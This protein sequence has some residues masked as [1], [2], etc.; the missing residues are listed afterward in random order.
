M[1]N[2]IFLN[3][4]IVNENLYY[5]LLTY[6]NS[7]Q[8]KYLESFEQSILYDDLND[9]TKT[10]FRKYLD[11]IYVC[12]PIESLVEVFPDQCKNINWA[13]EFITTFE[14]HHGY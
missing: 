7:Y 13:K 3:L 4:A 1:K 12:P 2:K 10:N 5:P 14:F 6:K 11:L 8:F 9:F